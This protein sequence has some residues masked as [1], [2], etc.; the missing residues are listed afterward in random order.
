MFW[1]SPAFFCASWQVRGLAAVS[2]LFN[3]RGFDTWGMD[4]LKLEWVPPPLWH[5]LG[6]TCIL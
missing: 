4:A 5:P 1:H 2:G 6:K 3:P